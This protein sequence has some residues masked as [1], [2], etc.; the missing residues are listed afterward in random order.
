MYGSNIEVYPQRQRQENL[1]LAKL[2]VYVWILSFQQVEVNNINSLGVK[3]LLFRLDTDFEHF[4]E[5]FF[6]IFDKI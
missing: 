5:S 3:L 6:R 1:F 2:I 4:W